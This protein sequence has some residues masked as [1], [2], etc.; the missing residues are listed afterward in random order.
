MSEVSECER[1]WVKV[2]GQAKVSLSGASDKELEVQLFDVLDE[3]FDKSNCWQ[4]TI[5]FPVVI[6]NLDY[7]IFPTCGRILRLNGVYDQH[8]T[9]QQAVM[10]TIGIVHFLYPYSSTQQMWASVIK[11][12]TDPLN[13]FPPNIPDW[14]L[15]AHGRAILAGILGN[16]MIQPGQ[17]YSNPTL[18][19]F[20]LRRFLDL[21]AHARVAALR[22]NTVGS[23]AWAFPRQFATSS[24][25][26]GVST[27]NVHPTPP[28][29]T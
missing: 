5:N 3:F 26:G 15:P 29:Q 2:L 21:I 22:M 25:R 6:N 27:F 16:M 7:P 14:V 28:G 20:H 4:E 10:P 24:Q 17:S 9:P 23:Q 11:T 1:Y 19:N 12:V 18:G 13:C 8:N